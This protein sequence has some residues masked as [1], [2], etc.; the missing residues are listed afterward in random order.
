MP[1][2][3]LA[4][5]IFWVGVVDWDVREFHGYNTPRGSTYNSYLIRDEKT[6]V[7]DGVRAGFESEMLRR[8]RACC[9]DRPVDYLVVNHVEPDHSG[10]LP[11]LVEELRPRKII[12]S[13]RGREALALHYG[14][15]GFSS[16]DVMIHIRERGPRSTS[17]RCLRST[18]GQRQAVRGPA[19]A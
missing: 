13:K 9:G 3:A 17:Q 1:P 8:V 6:C 10:G 11:R 16:W 4:D 7:V 15:V 14:S 18:S 2:I 19:G 12:A 5:D